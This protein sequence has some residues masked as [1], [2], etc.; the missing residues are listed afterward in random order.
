M[1]DIP[2]NDGHGRCPDD[3]GQHRHPRDRV[4]LV[5]TR[6]FAGGC[7]PGTPFSKRDPDP[8]GILDSEMME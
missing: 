2:G 1:V 4:V 3:R 5:R 8:R 6:H 7:Q